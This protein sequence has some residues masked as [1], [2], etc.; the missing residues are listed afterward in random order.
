M[1]LG[2]DG[3]DA[4]NGNGGADTGLM[5]D[6]VDTFVW[7]RVTAATSSRARRAP[8]RCSSTAL[9]APRTP[10]SRPT[11][12]ASGSSAPR[13]HHDGPDDTEFIDVQALGGPTA[14]VNDTSGN[15]LKRIVFD[16]EAA[17]GGG[18]GDGAADSVTVNG[19]TTPRHPGHRRTRAA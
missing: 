8:T 11:A 18:A 15:D 9:A 12:T 4:I 19:T 14:V 16:L 1:L 7:I 6:G 5:G 13:R 10:T 3:D 2:G 17:I